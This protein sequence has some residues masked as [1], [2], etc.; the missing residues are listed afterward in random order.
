MDTPDRQIAVIDAG[1]DAV[2]I[3][4][5]L[6]ACGYTET[7]VVA[8]P[9]EAWTAASQLW[10]DVFDGKVLRVAGV[11]LASGPDRTG[12][13]VLDSAQMIVDVIEDR[14]RLDSRE[15]VLKME[16]DCRVER[17]MERRRDHP[18]S[19]KATL[20]SMKPQRSRHKQHKRARRR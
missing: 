13:V 17:L 1:G 20:R 18:T 4:T 16:R 9:E 7:V 8:S 12:V 10:G 3:G 5:L 15:I 6:A 14:D 11:D 19:P 2:R